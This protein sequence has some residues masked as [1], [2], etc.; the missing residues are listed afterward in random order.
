M[1]GSNLVF[2]NFTDKGTQGQRL[3]NGDNPEEEGVYSDFFTE[4]DTIR[5]YAYSSNLIEIS[6]SSGNSVF[7]GTQTF[8]LPTD[9][10][11][12]GDIF[13]NISCSYRKTFGWRMI[14]TF[15][16]ANI[17]NKVYL[18][19]GSI[20]FQELNPFDTV[21]FNYLNMDHEE[22]I[23]FQKILRAYYQPK[24]GLQELYWP[25]ED[26]GT[27]TADEKNVVHESIAFYKLPLFTSGGPKNSFIN[28][29]GENRQGLTVKLE[30]E[31]DQE[32]V[33]RS[34]RHKDFDFKVTLF[35]RQYVL[36]RIEKNLILNNNVA[37]IYNF[38]Q[39]VELD[40]DD[41]G[42]NVIDLS[43]CDI[44]ASHIGILGFFN[45]N[46]SEYAVDA[47]I[48]Y[49]ELFLNGKSFSGRVHGLALMM[50]TDTVIKN[51]YIN[52]TGNVSQEGARK[53]NGYVLQLASKFYGPDSVPFN[54]FDS[55]QLK[56]K[57]CKYINYYEE[58]NDNK[59]PKTFGSGGYPINN[60]F[61]TYHPPK[62]TVTVFGTK[63][64]NYING[65]PTTTIKT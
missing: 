49:V 48:E 61:D 31:N 35:I 16:L 63:V 15:A 20:T 51:A 10:D 28:P 36:S 30:Y 7:G 4:R 56:I 43:F 23:F 32:R 38:T 27:R 60:R 11:A 19:L 6:P 33:A 62:A 18:N 65:V 13:I 54:K 47:N 14:N 5:R 58:L 39:G 25:F 1:S 12:I 64:I 44:F 17:I 21:F 37:K 9:M 57:W 3:Y 22:F 52:T 55:I 45:K 34:D 50:G 26:G 24:Y 29:V 59:F 46:P 53:F 40:L 8:H 42:F 41:S 2:N